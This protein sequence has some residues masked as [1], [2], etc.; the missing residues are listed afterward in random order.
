MSIVSN[1]P[2]LVAHADG[3]MIA[4]NLD[5]LDCSVCNCRLHFFVVYGDLG[6][7]CGLKFRYK[8]DQLRSDSRHD[9]G[10]CGAW[11]I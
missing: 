11:E 6:G 1:R 8:V 4:H 9:P 3:G 5:L 7:E 10:L 2:A